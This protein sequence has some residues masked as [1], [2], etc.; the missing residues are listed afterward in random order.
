M[1]A[2][3]NTTLIVTTVTKPATNPRDADAT[4]RVNIQDF[5][6]ECYEDIL[7]I[8]MDKLRR[9]K[10]KEVHARLDFEEGS[11]EKR[12]R[13]DSHHSSARA[14]TT[15]P[16]RLK[17]RDRLRYG[18][19]HV[20][21][22]LDFPEDRER[23][24]SVGESYDD[25]YS[26]SYHD[27]NRSCHIKKRRDNESPLS[28]VLKS[29]S[30]D[31]RTRMPNNVKTYDGI[32]DPEDHVKIFQAAAQVEWW[33]MPTWCHMFNSTLTGAAKKSINIKQN[34]EE[35]I[36]DFMKWFKVET[37]HIKGAPEC[38]RISGF[39]HGINNPELT[40]PLNEHVPKT[41]EEM[42]I[43]TTAFKRGETAVASKK[44]G[45]TS[46][47]AHDQSKR[48]TSEKMSDFRGHPREGRGTNRLTPLQGC[49]MRF[50]RPRRGY[51]PVRQKKRGQ[52][53][54]RAKAIQAEVQKL[55]EAWIMREVYY[56]DWLSNQ[57]MIQLA[58][59]GEEKIAFHTGQG[60]YCYT[61][62]PF[63]P[64]NA[65]AMYQRLVDKAFDSQIGQNI[66]VYVDDLVVKSY[67]EAEMLRD[68]DETFRTLRKINMK[69]NLKKCT[70]GEAGGV[71][72]GYVVTPEGIKSCPDNT[73]AVLQLPS[74][75]T[76]KEVQSLNGKLAKAEQAF[77]Q[78][79]QH[80]SEL[81]LLVAPKPNEELIV[82]LSATYGA[83]NV[84]LI[85]E[86]GATQ[87]PINFISHALQGPKLNY[88]H[89]EKLVM[90][91]VF[92]AKRR[93]YNITYRPR[94]SMKGQIPADFL[95]EMPNENLP[96]VPVAKTR[97][98][99]LTL[100]SD[101][102]SC[103][104]GSGD[105]LILTS[106]EGIE[107]TYVLRFQFAAS[108]NEA[109]YEALAGLRIAAQ[110]GVQNVH[111]VVPY[112]MVK[113]C[114]T[115]PGEDARDMIRKCNDCQ[116]H[117][118]VTRNPHQP[119]TPITAPWL[120]YKWR[121]DIAG[122]FP[123]GP[124]DVVYNDEELRLNLDLLEERHERATILEAKA[125]LKMTKYYNA[126]VRGV[127]FRPCDFV[128]RSND[129]SHAVAGGKLGPK[130]EGPYEVTKSLG[131][132]AYKLR[133]TNGTVLPRT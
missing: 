19:R 98:E 32:G 117:R 14:R 55:V 124:V 20:L 27:G 115:T 17:V 90:S 105:R 123:E 75:R 18:D 45:H 8:I 5:C 13:E 62:M 44:K 38:M 132:G 97:Q 57:V 22:R 34:D 126:R 130:L 91:L 69:L 89:M 71:F 82:Y 80:L 60:V 56:H 88:T 49:Q 42:M 35:I 103:V 119:L 74:P 68:D 108:N 106:L 9:D 4:P 1:S 12:T 21:D 15:K 131:D 30:S 25:S 33:A 63:G 133:S 110:M 87:T 40:K 100:F 52:A 101:G 46:L 59:P 61:K 79:K 93:E 29:D 107:F 122:P 51:S 73:A 109:E 112:A 120:F 47:R 86:R 6:E 127:T 83:I 118:L 67:T 81:P 11:R 72:L 23:F 58:E 129:A 85:T 37:E 2:M 7:P 70:F 76:I 96:A 125:K 114:W 28:S 121:I 95:T 84:V 128:Y 43:T 94:T 64:K 113:M 10:R 99:L 65:G 50:W 24:Y 36:E 92:A 48:Q 77:K 41:M 66:E 3:T 16:E 116:I 111:A 54:E 31:G 53:P 39:M 26:H 104:D 78:L 102:S